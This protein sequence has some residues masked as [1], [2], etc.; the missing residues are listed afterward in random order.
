MELY[1]MNIVEFVLYETCYYILYSHVKPSS[2]DLITKKNKL[3]QLNKSKYQHKL[4]LK[5]VS[6]KSY[7]IK[8]NVSMNQGNVLVL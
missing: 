1:P 8:S 7:T 2:T 3:K 4:F 5:K 6:H